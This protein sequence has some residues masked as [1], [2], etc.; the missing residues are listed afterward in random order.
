[1]PRPNVGPRDLASLHRRPIGLDTSVRVRDTSSRITASRHDRRARGAPRSWARPACH[2]RSRRVPRSPR[3][4]GTGAPP[5][6]RRGPVTSL[7]RTGVWGGPN[8]RWSCARGV[9]GGT[10]MSNRSRR[11]RPISRASP[12]VVPAPHTG[13]RFAPSLEH[14]TLTRDFLNHR[15]RFVGRLLDEEGE[16]RHRTDGSW[17]STGNSP[18]PRHPRV[19]RLFRRLPRDAPECVFAPRVVV[20]VV[21]P[22][23]VR[24]PELSLRVE[25]RGHGAR[26]GVVER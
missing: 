11:A 7:S 22:G 17:G 9:A 10:A 1:M 20:V 25:P 14:V 6:R 2:R 16:D 5:A 12:R 18:R 21:S 8:F 4:P 26:H 19:V 23:T 24:G 13:A 3:A 15:A